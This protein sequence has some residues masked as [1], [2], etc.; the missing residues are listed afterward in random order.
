MIE[1]NNDVPTRCMVCGTSDPKDMTDK[2]IKY[3]KE[4]HGG[5]VLCFNC[6]KVVPK[7]YVNDGG[8][9][10]S[11]DKNVGYVAPGKDVMIVRQNVLNRAV[12][13]YVGGK[14]ERESILDVAEEFEAWVLG[15]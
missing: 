7:S 14:I 9:P 6:Q 4:H 8:I 5:A 13:M 1:E 3:S 11:V 2:V 12:D 15:K 10:V